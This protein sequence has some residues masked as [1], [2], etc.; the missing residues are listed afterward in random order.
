VEDNV[1]ALGWALGEAEIAEIEAIFARH[2][3]NPVPEGWVEED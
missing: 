1:G 3:V 2:E